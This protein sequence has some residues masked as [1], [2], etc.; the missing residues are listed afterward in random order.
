MKEV[1]ELAFIKW[2]KKICSSNAFS[3][4]IVK[5]FASVIILL[6][7]FIPVYCYL[8][9]RYLIEPVGFWQ[10]LAILVLACITIGWLQ[11]GMGIV[12]GALIVVVVLE[13][14]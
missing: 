6:L 14:V 4:F 13:D 11:V 9:V 5:T 1:R 12:A 7:T 3:N 10:E 2:I 8:G